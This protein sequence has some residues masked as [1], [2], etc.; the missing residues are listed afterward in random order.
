VFFAEDAGFVEGLLAS[1]VPVSLI[2]PPGNQ[3]IVAH[4]VH[5]KSTTGGEVSVGQRG[6]DNPV[7]TP[8]EFRSSVLQQLMEQV[9]KK[10]KTRGMFDKAG[11]GQ[12][13]Q[14]RNLPSLSCHAP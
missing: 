7:E 5:P 10:Y 3:T 8:A 14:Q 2:P 12:R 4:T 1:G 13:V 9:Q 6:C 11:T